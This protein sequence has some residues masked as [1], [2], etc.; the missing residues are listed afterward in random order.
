MKI[1]YD[2]QDDI[3]LLQFYDGPIMTEITHNNI[4]LRFTSQGLGQIMIVQAA[5]SGLLP[6]YVKPKKLFKKLKLLTT[7]A[8]KS[9]SGEPVPVAKDSLLLSP[10]SQ[11]LKKKCCKS[12]KQGKRCKDCP[13]RV[14]VACNEKHL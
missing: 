1:V 12:Y 3:L 2:K 8:V 9:A 4:K 7:E 10:P 14:K 6:I 13:K 11:P 5:A